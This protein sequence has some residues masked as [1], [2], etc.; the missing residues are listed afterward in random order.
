MVRRNRDVVGTAC[1][2]NK[3]QMVLTEENEIKEV[4][5]DYHENLLNEGV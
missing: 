1:I 3:E 4:W 2:R 5:E